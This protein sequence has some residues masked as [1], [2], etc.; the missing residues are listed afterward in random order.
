MRSQ[1]QLAEL[2]DVL[3]QAAEYCA[4]HLVMQQN[5]VEVSPAFSLRADVLVEVQR[6]LSAEGVGDVRK[7]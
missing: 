7:M 5:D 6:A 3:T 4:V 1:Q 2:L